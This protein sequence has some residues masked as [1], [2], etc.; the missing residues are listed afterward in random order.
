M[1]AGCK[2]IPKFTTAEW[3]HEC[4]VAPVRKQESIPREPSSPF[5]PPGMSIATRATIV[6]SSLWREISSLKKIRFKLNRA[7]PTAI[8][9]RS[10]AS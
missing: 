2:L 8:P 10:A 5:S 9:S 7:V 3:P 4:R 1:P 6:A